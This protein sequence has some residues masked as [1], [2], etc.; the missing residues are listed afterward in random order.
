M[1]NQEFDSSVGA[2]SLL[3]IHEYQHA[4]HHWTGENQQQEL[5]L[6]SR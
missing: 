5:L 1:I 2:D 6:R 3:F 4:I